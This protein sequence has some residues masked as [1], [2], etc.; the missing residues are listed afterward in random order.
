MRPVSGIVSGTPYEAATW[1]SNVAATP[2]LLQCLVNLDITFQYVGQELRQINAFLFGLT[3]EVF[4]DASLNR[5]R[6]EDLCARRNVME[7]SDSFAEVDL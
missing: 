5:S 6:Q 3:G 1:E 4:P 7:T 2:V